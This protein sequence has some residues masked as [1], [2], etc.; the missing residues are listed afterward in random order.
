MQNAAAIQGMEI[1]GEELRENLLSCTNRPT[2]M[3]QC[4]EKKIFTQQSDASTDVPF[5]ELLTL[6]SQARANEMSPV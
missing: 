1:M 5:W 4:N 6:H 3:R 2:H